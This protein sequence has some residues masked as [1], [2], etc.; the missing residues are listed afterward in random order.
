MSQALKVLPLPAADLDEAPREPV[1]PEASA[2]VQAAAPGP[3]SA[4]FWRTGFLAAAAWII[5]GLL[6]RF[7]PNQVAGFTDWAF[8]EEFGLANVAVGGVILALALSYGGLARLPQLRDG[9]RLSGRWLVALPVLLLVWQVLT[10]KLTVL[11]G[12]FF[13][14]PQS[15][16]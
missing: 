2:P 16:V 9:L 4:R 12:P 11:P 1:A 6:V 10:A 3:A 5:E 15:L 8:T 13:A 14:P 7:W